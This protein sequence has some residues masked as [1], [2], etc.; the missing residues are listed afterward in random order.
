MQWGDGRSRQSRFIDSASMQVE[1]GESQIVLDMDYDDMEKY[2]KK[3][4]SDPRLEVFKN[5]KINKLEE[6]K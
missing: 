6:G 5:L 3:E 1:K 2:M 4:I